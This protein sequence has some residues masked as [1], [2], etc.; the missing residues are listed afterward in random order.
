[1]LLKEPL[2]F[3]FSGYSIW[4][5][6]EEF[7]LDEESGDLELAI[8]TSS[9]ALALPFGIPSP[10]VTAIYGMRHL[11][12]MEVRQRFQKVGKLI[13]EWC[14]IVLKQKGFRNDVEIKGVLG[15]EMDMAWMAATFH[16]SKEHEEFLDMLY[17]I[18]YNDNDESQRS[19][20]SP[21]DP[22]ISLA[23]D[24]ETSPIPGEVFLDVIQ[25]FPT[26][27]KNRA[28]TGISLWDTSGT[29]DSWKCLDRVC[30]GKG[31]DHDESI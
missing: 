10:H 14:P 2:R 3:V 13:Y 11:S 28:I 23:Y 22:H 9:I 21:W 1:M 25:K 12:E 15:G 17:H 31:D 5:E 24:N 6:P 30:W 20:R 27:Q 16:T 8:Q 4:L 29:I 26:L 7:K 19:S 18:F